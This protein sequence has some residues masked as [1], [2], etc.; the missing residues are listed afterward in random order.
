MEPTKCEAWKWVAWED[1]RASARKQSRM[2]AEAPEMTLF[3]PMVN[4]LT[5]YP[6]LEK[7]FQE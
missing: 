4:L 5:T 2:S 7:S 1:A 3:L 6:E